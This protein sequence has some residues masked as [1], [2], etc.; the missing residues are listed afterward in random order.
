MGEELPSVL[1][2]PG[3][4][5]EH[6]VPD[7]LRLQGVRGAFE[8]LS[9]LGSVCI[10]WRRRLD[11]ENT[12]VSELCDAYEDLVRE[13]ELADLTVIGVSTGSLVA[14]E[15]AAR[16]GARCDHLVLVAGGASVSPEGRAVLD[17]AAA[18]ARD[19][20]WRELAKLQMRA[21]YPGLPGRFYGAIGYLFPALYGTPED[22]THFIALCACARTADL[23]PR[24]PELHA[25]VL[26]I[27]GELDL[28]FPP[29]EIHKLALLCPEGES[30][31]IP[32]AGHGVF[33]SHS[34]E[35]NRRIREFT[36]RH[37]PAS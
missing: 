20:R 2:I 36:Q 8:E 23:F 4:E 6:V 21:F 31:I 22:P 29:D 34:A 14:I 11:D 27:A 33:K 16:L 5:P 10:A 17:Q 9:E 37:S 12:S 3:T 19:A 13:L 25:R 26:C 35:I 1:V 18:F 32:R 7:G 15:L 28:F 30:Q 24:V